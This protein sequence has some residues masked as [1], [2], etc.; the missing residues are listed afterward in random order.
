MITFNPKVYAHDGF[1]ASIGYFTR[2]K[3]GVWQLI[4]A[5]G[6]VTDPNEIAAVQAQIDAYD[7][8]PDER[9][10]MGAAVDVA[11][12]EARARY[13]TIAPGQDIVYELKRVQAEAHK[14]A[15]YPADLTDYPMIEAEQSARGGTAQAA[16]DY[17]LGKSIAWQQL[18]ASI[19][20]IKQKSK[21]DMAAATTATAIDLLAAAAISSLNA[22]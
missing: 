6:I 17:I 18:A 9:D 13:I 7:P 10:R 5:S 19:E 21:I 15:D 11:A 3:S 1:L 2:R 22:I 4:G 20:L 16:T 12:G 14:A 8:L